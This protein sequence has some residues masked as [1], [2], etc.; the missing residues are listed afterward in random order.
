MTF[1]TEKEK[2]ASERFM[3]V[4][5]TARQD[6]TANMSLVSGTTYKGTCYKKPLLVYVYSSTTDSLV[7]QNLHTNNTPASGQ[8]F[9]DSTT[10]EVYI[11]YGAG[12]LSDTFIDYN[13]YLT[14]GQTRYLPEIPGVGGFTVEWKPL[15]ETYPEISAS[16]ENINLGIFSIAGFDLNVINDGNWLGKFAA[17]DWSLLNH[18]MV[19]WECIN[20]ISNLKRVFTGFITSFA[21]NG[22]SGSITVLDKF[23]IL[24]EPA[25]MG[26]RAKYVYANANIID[27]VSSTFSPNDLGR[28]IHRHFTKRSRFGFDQGVGT[29]TSQSDFYT[30]ICSSYS[31]TISSTT[32]RVWVCGSV[33]TD[34]TLPS[35]NDIEDQGFG[36]ITATVAD[37]VLRYFNVSAPDNLYYN[38]GVRWQE[39]MT[40]YYG[41]IVSVGSF[42]H[43]SV[44]YNL[45]VLPVS[46]NVATTSSSFFVNKSIGLYLKSGTDTVNLMPTRDFTVNVNANGTVVVTLVNNF[47]ANF[48]SQ[49]PANVYLNPET[50]KL[51]YYYHTANSLNH[52]KVLRDIL[53][54]AGFTCN[55]AS[56]AAAESALAVDVSFSM[57]FFQG[58][59]LGSYAEYVSAILESVGGY[60][61]INSSDEITYNFF[62]APS[63]SAST[64]VD[65]SVYFGYS[66]AV[67]YQ[68]I[69]DEVVAKNI[70]FVNNKQS[71]SQSAGTTSLFSASNLK[72]RFLNSVRKTKTI[73]HVLE[74]MTSTI[75][76]VLWLNSNRIAKYSLSTAT[77]N[78]DSALGEDIKIGSKYLAGDLSTVDAK[79][80]STSSSGKQVRIEAL[81]LYDL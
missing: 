9:F 18:K 60:I 39:G 59:T 38:Q 67:Q 6:N 57:P 79:I 70:H 37:G 17:G 64:L 3:L 16:I 15:I 12:G 77:K 80:I 24:N 40:S 22:P 32:N 34:T 54:A 27:F 23:N 72:S 35:T 30:G 47:E 14:G 69:S 19:V 63:A 33:L 13:E 75:D 53:E 78:A 25:T 10:S 50:D 73:A 21:L 20:D 81:D 56:F 11:N 45:A 58:S 26:Q 66:L 1:A 42:T 4:K 46:G 48:P 43:L 51:C 8:Y 62:S 74:S 55:A 41:V 7:E 5:I 44:T 76:R 36:S 71:N 29:I 2:Q 68:D 65:E 31:E 49:F 28:P 52:A 61:S